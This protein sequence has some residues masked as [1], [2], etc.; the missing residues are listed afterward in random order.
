[1]DENKLSEIIA[2]LKNN[3]TLNIEL[4]FSKK[5]RK[6]YITYKPNVDDGIKDDIIKLIVRY[7]NK[8]LSFKPVQYSPTKAPKSG[9]FSYKKRAFN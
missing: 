4:Y 8:H 3:D 5:T 7:L 2:N 6:D 9:E 1:M